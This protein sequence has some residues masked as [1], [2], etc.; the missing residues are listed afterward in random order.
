MGK[1][2]PSS[3][4]I[5]T[6]NRGTF[7]FD[8]FEW[9]DP[10]KN[11]A[12]VLKLRS[13]WV[14][15]L[16]AGTVTEGM[17]AAGAVTEG[18][19]G[20]DAVTNTKVGSL[21]ISAD[22]IA[23]STITEDRINASTLTSK[24]LKFTGNV[25]ADDDPLPDGVN[26]LDCFL[27]SAKWSSGLEPEDGKVIC[28]E[29]KYIGSALNPR[30]KTNF[31]GAIGVWKATTN[32]QPLPEDW[33]SATGGVTCTNT[34]AVNEYV[35]AL[36]KICT[37]ITALANNGIA[38]KAAITLGAGAIEAVSLLVYAT[39]AVSGTLSLTDGIDQGLTTAFTLSAGL[40]TILTGGVLDAHTSRNVYITLDASG[41][42]FWVINSQVENSAFP[43][44]FTPSTR[45]AGSLEYM[46][47]LPSIGTAEIWIRPYAN[48]DTSTD[49]RVFR[50]SG[51]VGVFELLYVSSVDKLYASI[52]ID[53]SNYRYAYTTSAFTGSADLNKWMHIKIVWNIA[54]GSLSLYKDGVEQSTQSAGSVSSATAIALQIGCSDSSGY[55]FDGLI[56]DL[57]LHSTADT[58]TTHYAAGRPYYDESSLPCENFGAR[59]SATGLDLYRGSI[60]IM[61]DKG[62][63]ILISNRHGL[64]AKDAC[65]NVIH[66][67][68]D[69]VILSNQKVLGHSIWNDDDSA[70][71]GYNH[72]TAS[73]IKNID[74]TSKVGSSKNIKGADLFINGYIS[75]IP[76]AVENRLV[77]FHLYANSAYN[78]STLR[79]KIYELGLYC[80][81]GAGGLRFLSTG[82]MGFCPVFWVGS[83]CYI[84]LYLS[85][86]TGGTI[87][88][89]NLSITLNGVRA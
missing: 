30:V 58:S 12:P 84:S 64:K 63:E 89:S 62:R 39:G 88:A 32:Q 41:T 31:H 28:F 53:G 49:F 68:P 5:P 77:R 52:Y 45:A 70:L 37:K 24:S 25:H 33:S 10:Q 87:D 16:A 51:G 59:L 20:T 40:N 60:D 57:A 47:Q 15:E 54:T 48:Y 23:L 71:I 26:L 42:S 13:P 67:I 27:P 83:S 2:R 46:Y 3:L 21:A 55:E 35:A 17:I 75:I 50:L 4:D 43:T 72:T 11:A 1:I 74:I 18:K 85:V 56:S 86:V 19:I 36:G 14:L 6:W 61:D 69:T 44:P 22:K 8:A 82:S 66:D 65:G 79:S 78:S 38:Y 7:P 9:T 73:G 29:P 76:D 80:Y 81:A 34:T